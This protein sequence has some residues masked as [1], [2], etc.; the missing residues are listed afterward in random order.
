MTDHTCDYC[1]ESFANSSEL[2]GHVTGVHRLDQFVTDADVILDDIR[3]VA[4]MLGKSPTAKE[5]AEHREYPQRVCQ[6]KFG[7]WNEALDMAGFSPNARQNIPESELLAEITRLTE[8]IGRPPS[9]NEITQQGQFSR[10]A[11]FE[12]FESWADALQAA[13]YERPVIYVDDHGRLPYGT[14]WDEQRQ[15][16]LDRDGYAC[17]SPRC[18]ITDEDHLAQFGEEL[19]VHHIPRKHYIAENGELLEQRA[20]EL[21]NL[22]ALCAQHHHRWEKFTPLIPDIR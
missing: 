4:A 18:S 12:R 21:S 14:N 20:N 15:K 2:G 1:G 22:I 16:A 10:D 13:G 5:M 9:S 11:Y 6:D 3:R 17:Q 7:S 19:H 8:E